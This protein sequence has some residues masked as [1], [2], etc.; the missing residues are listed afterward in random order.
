MTPWMSIPSVAL[1]HGLNA[2]M[3]PR[4]L[5]DV[6][7]VAAAP[8]D[9]AMVTVEAVPARPAFVQLPMPTAASPAAPAPER[10]PA[11][12]PASIFV[13]VQRAD[14]SVY[15]TWPTSAAADAAAWLRELLR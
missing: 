14:T 9:A 8:D 6:E 2:N 12:A 11:P 13:E 4:W 1:A 15:V 10:E 5:R 7:P 3:L